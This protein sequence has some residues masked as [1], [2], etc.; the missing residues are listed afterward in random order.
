MSQ[1]ERKKFKS[2]YWN[3][4]SGKSKCW[5]VMKDYVTSCIEWPGLQ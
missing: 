2:N 3:N 5:I 1:I 4:D